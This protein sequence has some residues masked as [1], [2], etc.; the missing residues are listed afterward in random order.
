MAASTPAALTRRLDDP[1]V[2]ERIDF[3]R[4]RIDAVASRPEEFR[5]L[6]LIGDLTGD[7]DPTLTKSV[8]SVGVKYRCKPAP[9]R[10]EG[11]RVADA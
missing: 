4:W 8:S 9:E 7:A 3:S 10:I 11:L 5:V 2:R 6:Q 1:G